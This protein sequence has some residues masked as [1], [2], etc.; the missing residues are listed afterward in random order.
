[1]EHS[2]PVF[3]HRGASAIALENTMKAFEKAKELG[4]DGI[5]LDVQCTKDGVLVIFHDLNL[6]RLVGITKLIT[7]CTAEELVKYRL[8]KNVFKRRFSSQHMPTL[9]QVVAWAN[10][11]QIA[12]NIEL[13][14][15][16][17]THRQPLIEMLL[18]LNLPKGSHFSSFHDELLKTVKMQR[19]DFQTAILVS[20]AFKWEQLKSSTHIDAV[21]A[22]K[23]YYKPQY[24]QICQD[25]Q[26]GMR[27]YNINGKESFLLNPH[28]NV[29]GWITDY[30][31]RVRKMQN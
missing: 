12:L 2:I 23:Q 3:A 22:N 10:L 13:K 1:M 29:I 8:G 11:N 5:E 26:K 20:K 27:F 28:P 31:D 18:K 9:Q 30:P 21:H 24:L 25:A 15:S 7:E 16:L 19:H 6:Y 14:E 4:A 17:I